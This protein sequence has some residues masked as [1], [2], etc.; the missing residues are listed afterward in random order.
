MLW[1]KELKNVFHTEKLQWWDQRNE[2]VQRCKFRL[3][4]SIWKKLF[5]KGLSSSFKIYN[6]V[7]VFHEANFLVYTSPYSLHAVTQHIIV[8]LI[9]SNL[10]AERLNWK[11]LSSSW[12]WVE[13]PILRH[14]LCLSISSQK[15][16]FI[17]KFMRE[18]PN[19]HS[20]TFSK[21]KII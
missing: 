16:I 8:N 20:S 6:Q 18:N 9:I 14:D 5:L 13:S 11:V 12:E 1:E 10:G 4:T 2:K 19:P 3:L 17:N 7:D 21:K 15:Y